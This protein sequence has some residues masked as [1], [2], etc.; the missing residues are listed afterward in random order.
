MAITTCTEQAHSSSTTA[1]FTAPA[2]I[3]AGDLLVAVCRGANSGIDAPADSVPS[4]FTEIATLSGTNAGRRMTYSYK[5]ADG[6]E[7]SE[8]LD[9]IA[10]DDTWINLLVQFRAD[11]PIT[12]VAVQSIVSQLTSNNP[13]SKTVTSAT[14]AVPL[15]AITTW[16]DS[17]TSS[18]ISPRTQSPALTELSDNTHLYLGYKFYSSSPADVTFDMDDEGSSNALVGWYFELTGTAAAYT[19][20]FLSVF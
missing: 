1:T 16:M 17:P 10:A 8:V 5:I 11:E 13:T 20:R 6:T 18:D 9:S 2:S 15:L 19:S 3:N 12:A 7:D 4:G 14:G